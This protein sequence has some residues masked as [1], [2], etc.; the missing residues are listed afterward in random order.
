[1]KYVLIFSN[2]NQI[3]N[4]DTKALVMDENDEKSEV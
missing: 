3:I 2:D 4:I 1:M